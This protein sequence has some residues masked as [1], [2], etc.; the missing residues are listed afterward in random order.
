M[1][2]WTPAIDADVIR[3]E[4]ERYCPELPFAAGAASVLE[5]P[6]DWYED[7]RFIRL[8]WAQPGAVAATDVYAFYAPGDFRPL[9]ATGR[10]IAHLNRVGPL[11][12]TP[13]ATAAYIALRLTLEFPAIDLTAKLVIEG[14]LA[15]DAA[16]ALV[17]EFG[18]SAAASTL[19]EYLTLSAEA[20]ASWNAAQWESAAGVYAPAVIPLPPDVIDHAPTIVAH[21]NDLPPAVKAALQQSSKTAEIPEGVRR[22]SGD[23]ILS[24]GVAG[25]TNRHELWML[26]RPESGSLEIQRATVDIDARGE[27]AV[28]R[29][30]ASEAS[31]RCRFRSRRGADRVSQTG[32]HG[33]DR[34]AV[35]RVS[36]RR[37]GAAAP[38]AQTLRCQRR[39]GAVPRYAAAV[40]SALS[41]ARDPPAAAPRLSPQLCAD[42][43]RRRN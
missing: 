33:D 9:D 23:V 35:A 21:Q 10:T 7:Y 11:T 3:G 31:A 26:S 29:S 37:A 34:R 40:L 30:G 36:R 4:A 13:D 19:N 17:R 12:L 27:L 5:C 32:G 38:G 41:A 2:A 8:S 15:V 20:R 42:R 25:R 1:W 6:C 43:D 18:L 14:G 28:A 24:G 39:A 16:Q 22:P